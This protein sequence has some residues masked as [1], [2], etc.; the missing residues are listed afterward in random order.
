MKLSQL[1]ARLQK[2]IGEMRSLNEACANEK[3]EVRELTPEESEKYSE[4]EKEV[5]VTRSAI[6][7]LEKIQESENVVADL[8]EERGETP[9]ISI[10]RENNCNESGEYRGYASDAHGFG[11]YLLDVRA[12]SFG[13][14]SKKLKEF[15]SLAESHNQT[16]GQDG[17][18]LVQTD[19]SEELFS[20]ATQDDLTSKCLNIKVSSK[21]NGTSINLVDE[22]SLE[23]GSLYG[24]L[25]AKLLA[26]GEEIPL[27]K[28]KF[29]QSS[30]KLHKV[31]A[32]AMVTEEQ[33]EDASQLGSFLNQA[34]PVV[35]QD[36]IHYHL[37][38]GDGTKGF[39]G[40]LNAGAL[41]TAAKE[42]GQTADT[43][44]GLNINNMVDRLLNPKLDSTMFLVHPNVPKE[45]R[46]AHLAL[47]NSDKPIY[48][49]PGAFGS[50][51]RYLAGYPVVISQNCKALGD[52]GDIV[53]VDLSG[54]AFFTKSGMRSSV[55]AHVEF[56]KDQQVFKW[57]I[58]AAGMPLINNAIK[59]R[60]GSTTRSPFIALEAR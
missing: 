11:E 50:D 26:E 31:G 38:H 10:T 41:I 9:R 24:G 40:I 2:L 32:A 59:D 1:K 29:K 3:G 44:N 21:S 43:V 58:R 20:K 60:H 23:R 33:L 16:T 52:L 34:L 36:E 56:L 8:E 7:R 6:S 48:A 30:I 37:L 46:T 4:F 45:L 15:R 54:Y 53:L 28:A 35:M 49:E 27:S 19:H 57:T 22:T 14:E 18:F 25:A 13:K 51:Q 42:S 5:E 17:G 47:T 55:S 39:L 12:A